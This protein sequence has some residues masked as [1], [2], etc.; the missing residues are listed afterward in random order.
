LFSL[1]HL[2]CFSNLHKKHQMKLNVHLMINYIIKH[3]EKYKNNV[4]KKKMY[5]F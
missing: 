1:H 4:M 2:I 3:N 5:Y